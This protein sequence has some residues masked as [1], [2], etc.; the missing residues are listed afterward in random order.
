MTTSSRVLSAVA[1]LAATAG[2]SGLAVVSAAHRRSR[3]EHHGPQWHIRL[4]PM[5][6]RSLPPAPAA[7]PVTPPDVTDGRDVPSRPRHWR[8]CSTAASALAVAVVLSTVGCAGPT[9]DHSDPA[10]AVMV[11]QPLVTAS[12]AVLDIDGLG[13]TRAGGCGATVLTID[14]LLTAAHCVLT[15]FPP[16]AATDVPQPVAPDQ[17]RARIGS[18]GRTSGGTVR[19]VTKIDIDPE[20][21]YP[22]HAH[23]LAVLRLDQPLTASAVAVLGDAAPGTSTRALVWTTTKHAD[24]TYPP[25]AAMASYAP[26]VILDRGRCPL[27]TEA[28][29]AL[30]FDAAAGAGGTGSAGSG[31]FRVENPTAIRLVGVISKS[32]NDEHTTGIANPLLPQTQW[33]RTFLTT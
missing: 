27:L 23:D 18:A 28:N 9:A 11:A 6:A 21:T 7:T 32:G 14:S 30:C 2:A 4:S 19:A 10:K 31:L 3:R 5:L 29:Q 20:F 26:A 13:G 22:D 8:R 17:V 1:A 12:T 25:R 15:P 16:L 33:L 24:G